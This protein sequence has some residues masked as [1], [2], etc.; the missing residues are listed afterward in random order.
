MRPSGAFGIGFQSI[1][2]ITD[3]VTLVTRKWGTD[4]VVKLE[5]WNPSGNEK[6]NILQKTYKDEFTNFGT[7]IDCDLFF[8]SIQDGLYTLMK[9]CHWRQ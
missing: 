5:M 3:K 8:S 7:I 2:L 4:D 1:F 6:G 9:R